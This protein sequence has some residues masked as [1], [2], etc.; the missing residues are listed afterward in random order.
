MKRIFT[1]IDISEEVRAR[2]SESV[3]TLGREFPNIR[4]GWEKPEKL[5]LTLKFLGDINEIQLRNLTYAVAQTAKQIAN[6]N[7]QIVGTGVFPSMRNAR[8]LWL[9]LKDEKGNLTHLNEIFENECE[10]LGFTREK[11]N[12]KPHLTIA[13][14]REPQKS[15]EL[16]EKHLSNNFQS[17]GFNINQIVIYESVLKPTGSVYTVVSSH[18]FSDNL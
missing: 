17:E 14:L 15:R 10:N 8:I 16:S 3:E 1:A 12:F 11:R 18:K 9:G 7:L 2:V 6:F 5:H 4:V 13:R